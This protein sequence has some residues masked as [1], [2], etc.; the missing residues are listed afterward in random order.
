MSWD[1]ALKDGGQSDWTVCTVWLR[2]E[3]V[4]YLLHMERG[5]YGFSE[6]RTKYAELN[7][8]YR[9]REILF[10]ETTTG[11]AIERDDNNWRYRITLLPIEQD[12]KGRVY[13]MQSKFEQGIVQFPRNAPFMQDVENE[14]LSYPYGQTDDIIDSI[15]QALGYR[16]SS[17][18]LDNVS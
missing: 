6:L 12:R 8:K 4:Y 11:I 10:E 14:L 15:S 1:T 3:G 18:T 7:Q 13:V 16:G 2:Y 9:P 17:Y 5:I